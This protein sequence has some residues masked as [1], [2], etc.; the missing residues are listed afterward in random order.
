MN[1][2][3]KPIPPTTQLRDKRND[4]VRM[5]AEWVVYLSGKHGKAGAE[6][7]VRRR[8]ENG[9]LEVVRS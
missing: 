5:A 4:D 8:V 9:T 1:I 6:D 7:E 2:D 3:Q